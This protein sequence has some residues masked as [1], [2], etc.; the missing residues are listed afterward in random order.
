[1][2]K[3]SGGHGTG[4]DALTAITTRRSVGKVVEPGPDRDELEVLLGAAA[5]APDHGLLKPWRVVVLRG[6]ARERLGEAF[7]TAHA[8]REPAADEAALA[9]SAGKPLRAPVLVA[10]LY[11]PRPS[12]KVPAWEQLAAT[13][14][15]VQN[16]LLAA[17]ARGW[18]AMW[19]TGWFVAAEPVRDALGAGPGEQVVAIVYLGTPGAPSAP[20]RSRDLDTVVAWMDA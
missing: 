2:P 5:A 17:H 14:A 1:M 12:V 6:A 18:G 15:A 11:E 8:Q 13:A 7:A 10:V 9:G 19:R 4:M 3:A 20:A 16:L